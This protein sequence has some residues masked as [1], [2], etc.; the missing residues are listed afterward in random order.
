MITALILANGAPGALAATIASLVPGVADGAIADAIVLVRGTPDA[1]HEALADA[2]G[3]DLVSLAPGEDPWRAGAAR[4]RRD[5]LLLL[6][7]GDVPLEGFARP[8]ERFA[9]SAPAAPEALGRLRRADAGLVASLLARL[10][11]EARRP[12]SGDLVHARHLEP[13]A[14]PRIA[15]LAATIAREAMP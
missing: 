7:S 14:R 8:L 9:G 5:W 12:R 3:A 1:A 15:R 13:G 4:A 11:M 6:E 10:G 2:A